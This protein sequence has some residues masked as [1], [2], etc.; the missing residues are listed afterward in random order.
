MGSK[1]YDKKEPAK[2]EIDPLLI[3]YVDVFFIQRERY[4]VIANPLTKF[5]FII[6]HYTKKSQ[7]DFL[8]ALK[9]KLSDAMKSVNINPGKYLVKCDEIFP[10]YETNRS[11]SAHLSRINEEYVYYIS[12]RLHDIYPPEDEMFYNKL[13]GDYITTYNKKDYDFPRRRFHHELILRRWD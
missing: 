7:P 13:V 9:D 8:Q 10:F 3:W 1:I 12:G 4:L 2:T 5:T 6:F 11:A